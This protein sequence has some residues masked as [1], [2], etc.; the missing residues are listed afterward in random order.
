MV[1]LEEWIG[2]KQIV[3]V[4]SSRLPPGAQKVLGH[5]L[6]IAG[7]LAILDHALDVG[8]QQQTYAIQREQGWIWLGHK[9]QGL[10]TYVD[11]VL[12]LRNGWD[13]NHKITS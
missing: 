5:T 4:K 11:Q 9:G 1:V 6:C 13:L 8:P 3:Y 7:L 10:E 2:D 12:S